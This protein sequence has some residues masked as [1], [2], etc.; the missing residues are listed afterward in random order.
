MNCEIC[1][2]ENPGWAWTDTHGVAQCWEC[3]TPYRILHYEGEG[4]ATKRVEKPPELC[5]KPEYVP[6]LQA[7]WNEKHS[8]IPSGYSFPGGQEMASRSQ[9]E[10][11]NEWMRENA[12]RLLSA[13]EKVQA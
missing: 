2:S 8:T 10:A 5:V 3:G 9:A 11:F 13:N 6:V 4:E 7:Y 12:E 1:K